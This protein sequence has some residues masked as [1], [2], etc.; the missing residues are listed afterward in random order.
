MTADAAAL[1]VRAGNAVI[2]RGG[3]ECLASNLAI[4]AAVAQGS[5]KRACRTPACRSCARPTAPPSA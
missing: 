2:L 1:C 3:S 5:P 4:H